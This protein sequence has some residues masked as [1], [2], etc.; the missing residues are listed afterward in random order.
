M[1]I[2]KTEQVVMK[3]CFHPREATGRPLPGNS[4]IQPDIQV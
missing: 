4:E 2:K 3:K 1:Q